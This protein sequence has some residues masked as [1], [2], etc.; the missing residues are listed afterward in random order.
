MESLTKQIDVMSDELQREFDSSRLLEQKCEEYLSQLQRSAEIIEA[1]KDA[2]QREMEA[3]QIKHEQ[4]DSAF[5]D[6]HERMIGCEAEISRLVEDNQQLLNLVRTETA[7]H[8]KVKDESKEKETLLQ[9][10]SKKVR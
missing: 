6:T 8:A 10:L 2:Y 4:L 9:E 3:V 1:N 7:N 5:R